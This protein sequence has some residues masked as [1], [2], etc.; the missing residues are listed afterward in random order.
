M[1]RARNGAGHAAQNASKVRIIAGRWRGTRLEVP[2][3]EGL[4][5]SPDRVR[6][7]LFNWLQGRVAGARCLDLFAGSGALGFEAA[8]RGAAEVVMIERDPRALAAL[9]AAATRLGADRVEILGEDALVWL[10]R[11]ADRRFDLVFVDPPFAAGLHQAVLD[12]L[13]PWLAPEA[14]VY[15][16]TASDGPVPS[17]PGREPRRQGNTRDTRSY[18]FAPQDRS[19]TC[20]VAVTL[21]PSPGEQTPPTT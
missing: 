14:W 15:V 8:S 7:T 13:A 3:V 21:A 5:P 2:S 18:R 20:D 11:A 19:A 16:E 17:L 6:E 9:R 1:R 10:G 4:R 12:R